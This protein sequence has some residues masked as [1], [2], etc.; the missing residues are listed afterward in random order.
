[1]RVAEV[2]Q[3]YP[4]EAGPSDELLEGVGKDLRVDGGAVVVRKDVAVLICSRASRRSQELDGTGIKIDR[5]PSGP[6][7]AA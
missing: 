2:V 6:S 3:A 7:L 1:M 5:P 4:R